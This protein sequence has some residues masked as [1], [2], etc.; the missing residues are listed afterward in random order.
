MISVKLN[1]HSKWEHLLF[2]RGVVQ[3]LILYVKEI[4]VVLQCMLSSVKFSLGRHTVNNLSVIK[5]AE[6]EREKK[7]K[8]NIRKLLT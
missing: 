8:I 3:T 5:A 6:R 1:L 4:S 2:R 7:S